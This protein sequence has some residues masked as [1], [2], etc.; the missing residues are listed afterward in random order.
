M[1]EPDSDVSPQQTDSEALSALTRALAPP[2]RHL[3]L[4]AVS[5]GAMLHAMAQ[6]SVSVVLPQLQGALS[7]TPD[8]ISW[9][10]TLAVVG[11]IVAT[12]MSGW[13]VDK[14]GWRRA[15]LIAVVG[16]GIS[17]ILCATA[18]S[19]APM[20]AYRLLQ[21]AFGAPMFPVAQAILLATYPKEDRAWSQSVHGIATVL[22]Q[23]VAPVI[24]AYFAELYDWRWTFWYLIPLVVIAIFMII[25]WLP[26]GGRRRDTRL[27]WPAFISLSLAIAAFQ[28]TL[29]RGERLDWFESSLIV[30]YTII[31]IGAF[32]YFLL[33]TVTQERPF[34]ELSLFLDRNF[35]LGT[36]LI[37]IFGAVSFLPNYLYPVILGNLQGYPE[38]AI[39][40]ILFVRGLGMLV[41]FML[42]SFTAQAFPR[43][44]LV[45]GFLL[46][47]VAGVQG[48]FFTLNVQYAHVAWASF[49]Q[50]F[51]VALIWIP[52]VIISFSTLPPVLLAQ[53][54]ALFHLLRQVASSGSL[55][56]LVAV[57]LRTGTISYSELS[58]Q[59][60]PDTPDAPL[61]DLG[62]VEGIARLSAEVERQ[63]QMIGYVNAFVLYTGA[64]VV[65]M[66]LSLVIGGRRR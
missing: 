39:G 21:G 62:S 65:G 43:I 18:T 48:M 40:M 30:T 37:I 5:M 15:S 47:G 38:D 17:T 14:T 16:F 34:I 4:I 35:A 44:T 60:N 33:R 10:I 61:R 23:A 66:V 3:I 53:S 1:P 9:V 31:S 46:T 52:V 20:L 27:D 7:A 25:V 36:L 59:I 45:V 29:D 42:V 2:Q 55:A 50:G 13:L 49:F 22:G 58:W 19:L 51:G 56:I 28:L 6:T 24:G 57:T 12:P 26:P 8:Q 41:G 54:S 11:S 63:A 32:A 64:C